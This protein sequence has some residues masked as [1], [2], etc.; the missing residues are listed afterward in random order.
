MEQLQTC[1]NQFASAAGSFKKKKK[2]FQTFL[3]LLRFHLIKIDVVLCTY[4]SNNQ[5]H[6][7]KTPVIIY[8]A[9]SSE[10]S[11]ST[12]AILCRLRHP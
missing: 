11:Q 7:H 3:Y 12:K 1:H 2:T 6:V 5:T 8:K 4:I 9:E 10:N